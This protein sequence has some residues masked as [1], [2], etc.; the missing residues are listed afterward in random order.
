MM[1]NLLIP[2]SLNYLDL[3]IMHRVQQDLYR[4]KSNGKWETVRRMAL[5]FG[6]CW[7]PA[8]QGNLAQVLIE[9]NGTHPSS[10]II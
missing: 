5:V 1:H 9:A 10:G 6:A 2:L 8:A 3:V 4:Y 7:G